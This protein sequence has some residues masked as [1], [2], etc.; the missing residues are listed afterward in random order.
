MP[1]NLNNLVA[2]LQQ[3]TDMSWILQAVA[4]LTSLIS[5]LSQDLTNG[6]FFLA[7][8]KSCTNIFRKGLSS[9]GTLECQQLPLYLGST[10]SQVSG[11]HYDSINE[12]IFCSPAHGVTLILHQQM[13]LIQGLFVPTHSPYHEL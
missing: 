2:S 12:L 9:Y 7:Y 1:Q 4:L 6:L 5:S 13:S 10:V 3:I 8:V 11:V